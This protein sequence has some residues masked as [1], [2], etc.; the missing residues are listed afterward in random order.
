[1]SVFSYTK[2]FE[3]LSTDSQIELLGTVSESRLFRIYKARKGTKYVILKA[4][5][6]VDAMSVEIL[7]REYELACDLNHPCIARTLGFEEETQVGLAIVM[8][9]V[10]GVSLDAFITSNPSRTSRRAVLQDILDGVDY[11]HH[12]GI[13][14]N[15]LKP[16][17]ILVTRTG[18]ARILDFGLSASSDSIYRGCQGGTD[19]YTAPEI[20]CGDKTAGP[21]SD[22]YSVGRL[23]SLLFGG[24]AYRRIIRACTAADPA[25]RLRDIRALRQRIR[26]RDRMPYIGAVVAVVL[27]VASLLIFQFAR[28]RAGLEHQVKERVTSYSENRTDSLEKVR[29]QRIEA[30][31]R[32]YEQL[33]EPACRKTLE[34]IRD[35]QYREAAQVLTVP[36]Y[37]ETVPCFD[38][39]CRRFTV[40]TDGSVPDEL[41]LVGEVFNACRQCIDSTLNRLPSIETL[42]SSQRDSML[43]VIE[44]MARQVQ[45]DE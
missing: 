37:R 16:D 26:R 18:A 17:N 1:M 35:Q 30:L 11:L 5:V 23:M 34:K 31:R 36:Y 9:Y 39:I 41:I 19:G 27:L 8:E 13:L 28:Q 20:L 42:P 38:S 45:Q 43:R 14:H 22:I 3:P 21:A 33:F 2:D 44:Q 24:H 40:H 7:R 15:D 29:M 10:E 4:P 6:A 32:G 12:R 25:E